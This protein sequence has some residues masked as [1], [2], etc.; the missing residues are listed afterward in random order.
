MSF[1]QKAARAERNKL[2]KELE[3]QKDCENFNS[4]LDHIDKKTQDKRDL[5]TVYK[6][7]WDDQCSMMAADRQRRKDFDK[8]IQEDKIKNDL[9]KEDEIERLAEKLISQQV[10]IFKGLFTK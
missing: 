4:F 1:R 5:Y 6:R 10:S 7:F 8:A 9:I 3:R 2:D